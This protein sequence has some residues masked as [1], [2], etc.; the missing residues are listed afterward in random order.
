MT[1][2]LHVVGRFEFCWQLLH[3]ALSTGR[4]ATPLPTG[5]VNG[6]GTAEDSARPYTAYIVEARAKAFE[7]LW[8][9]P[10]GFRILLIFCSD[11]LFHA[12]FL[13]AIYSAT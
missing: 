1:A 10:N 3:N 4:F 2:C 11:T 12:D 9:E 8:A 5:L 7:S 13:D 6:W